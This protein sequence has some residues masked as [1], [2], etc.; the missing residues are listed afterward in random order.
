MSRYLLIQLII[1]TSFGACIAVGLYFI[2]VPYCLLW[3][4]LAAGLRFVPYFG[5]PISAVA[6]LLMAFAATSGWTAVILTIVLYA[7]LELSIANFVE[8]WL[9]GANTRISPLAILASAVF[10]SWL[11]GPIGLLLSTPLTVCLVVIGRHVPRLRY[12]SVLLGDEPVLVPRRFYQR[13]LAGDQAEAWEIAEEKLRVSS[14]AELYDTVLIPGL[15]LAEEDRHREEL[16]ATR[17]KYI[18]QS[19]RDLLED[20]AERPLEAPTPLAEADDTPV[21]QRVAIGAEPGDAARKAPEEPPAGKM[22]KVLCL[23]ANDEADE[24]GAIMLSHLLVRR[25]MK[26]EALSFSTLAGE[27]LEVVGEK[28]V[29]LVCVSVVPPEGLRHARYLCKRL[30]ARYPGLKIVA[31]LWRE[32]GDMEGKLP[33]GLADEVVTSLGSAV[34]RIG[35]LASLEA[36]RTDG[37]AGPN[38]AAGTWTGAGAERGR[39]ILFYRGHHETRADSGR[40]F[41]GKGCFTRGHA[42]RPHP[43]DLSGTPAGRLLQ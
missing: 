38:A 18:F 19:I 1:N 11:W 43:V 42:E 40:C 28:E 36:F 17:E 29:G 16:D 26:A 4:V 3:G 6:P 7:A 27:R 34:E 33:A 22:L 2:G 14:L 30:R 23:P 39:A 10:W 32:T 5:A 8:P 13:L 24:M 31:G 35:A 37:G 20:L 15:I 25:G 41:P 21:T 9:Y 12:L